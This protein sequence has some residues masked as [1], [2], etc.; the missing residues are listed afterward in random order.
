[1]NKQEMK[2][3]YESNRIEGIEYPSECYEQDLSCIPEIDG[4]KRA[5]EYMKAH[6]SDPIMEHDIFI[7]HGMFINGLVDDKYAGQ[8]R[9]CNVRIGTHYGCYPV[10]IKPLMAK[11]LKQAKRA[12]TENACWQVHHEFEVIHPF[13]DGNGRTGRLILTWLLLK[14]GHK[15][16]VIESEKRGEYYQM[17]EAYRYAKEISTFEKEM[18][19]Q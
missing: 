6:C 11:L 14:N 18:K 2:F 5:F 1:M 16:Q 10:E 19:K 15:I 4:H 8:Y 3:V 17:I 13:V 12:K 7:M 9:D